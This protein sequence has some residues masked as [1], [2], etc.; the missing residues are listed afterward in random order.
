MKSFLENKDLNL[1]NSCDHICMLF[2]NMDYYRKAA[3]DFIIDGLTSNEQVLCVISEYSE[4]MLKKDL[5]DKGIDVEYF[6]RIC[7]LNIRNI[8]K[9]YYASDRFDPE[10]TIEYWKEQL[11]HVKEQNF[12]SFRAMGEMVS[13]PD[14]TCKDFEK[15]IDYELLINKEI[16]RFNSGQKYLCI[17]NKANFPA[18]ILEDV[19][20]KHNIVIDSGE[21]LNPNPYYIDIDDQLKDY[22][23]KVSFRSRFN[24][25]N[26]INRDEINDSKEEKKKKKD[27]EILR[28]VLRATGDGIW[29]L[30][31]KSSMINLSSTFFEIVE[32]DEDDIKCNYKELIK[33][34]HDEDIGEFKKQSKKCL[35]NEIEYFNHEVR[36][37]NKKGEWLWLLI[38]GVATRRDTFTGQAIKMVGIFNNIT[39]NKK[40]KREL[41][42]KI[43]F[44]KIRTDFF[45]NLSHEFR[46]PLNVILGSIQLQELYMS[47]EKENENSQKYKRAIKSMKQNC[48]RLLRLLNN[49]IDITRIDTGFYNIDLENY[50]IVNLLKNIVISVEDYVIK[51]KLNIDFKCDLDNLVLSCDPE[52]IERVLLNLLS[53]AIKFTPAGGKITVNVKEKSNKLIIIVQDTGSGIPKDNINTIFDRFSQV[54]KSL[55]R[56]HEGS[57]IGLSLV[58]SIIE[59]HQG[60]VYLESELNKGSKFF[61]KLPI[62]LIGKSACKDKSDLVCIANVER[63]NIEFADIYSRD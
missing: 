19:I 12:C 33:L 59:M 50:D 9:I 26:K 54:D 31:I 25:S 13:L 40:I 61:I 58:K 38:K 18:Y 2:D 42:D 4:S 39:E 29:E 3:I 30:D 23:N 21:V 48:Y 11:M 35:L 14:W 7:Q 57:G 8:K 15:V 5:K 53:N 17:Y 10:E 56:N 37:K 55:T 51:Q 27:I 46:T 20:K 22:S 41:D 62:R 49:L 60:E 24:L 63:M 1:Q 36:V 28:H 44:E 47:R 52:K 16:I 43:C 34:V 6:I 45:A 32:L